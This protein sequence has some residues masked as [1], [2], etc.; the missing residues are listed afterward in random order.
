MEG[1]WE[2]LAQAIQD[3]RRAKG[4]RQEDL[5]EAAGVARGTIQNLESG[6]TFSRVPATL[7]HV[8]ATLGWPVGRVEAILSGREDVPSQG[9]DE[10]TASYVAAAERLAG[11]LPL[12]IA[13]ELRSGQ[14]IDT[15]VIELGPPGSGTHMV[16]VLKRDE[17]TPLDD[18][19]LRAQL[20]EWS[21]IQRAIRAIAEGSADSP[22]S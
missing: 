4:W 9:L 18:A 3:S 14:V 17:D 15:D 5:A 7:R 1:T 13:Q 8:V 19:V 16:I 2:R 21:M 11:A 10:A 12:R 22:R 20:G 6:R